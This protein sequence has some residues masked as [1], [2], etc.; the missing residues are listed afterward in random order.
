[1]K[2]HSLSSPFFFEELTHWVSFINDNYPP[3]WFFLLIIKLHIPQ[4]SGFLRGF[5][6]HYSWGT[7][8]FF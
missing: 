6:P 3:G 2:K 5:L 8:M 7:E 4:I 1:M